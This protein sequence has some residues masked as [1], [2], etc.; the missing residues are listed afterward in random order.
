MVMDWLGECGYWHS[1]VHPVK[2]I[3]IVVAM[4][5]L[6]SFTFVLLLRALPYGKKVA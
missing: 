2:A 3:P 1:K 6:L 5:V 4:V